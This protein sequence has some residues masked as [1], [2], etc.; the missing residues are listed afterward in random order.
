MNTFTNL[1]DESPSG[2]LLLVP[3]STTRI[4]TSI[5]ASIVAS[6]STIS[7][8]TELFLCQLSILT[9]IQ[10]ICIAC[11]AAVMKRGRT[12]QSGSGEEGRGSDGGE[13]SHGGQSESVK[14][15]LEVPSFVPHQIHHGKMT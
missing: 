11:T 10:G 12:R 15:V 9:T 14:M 7:S 5:V 4:V 6:V 3:I 13:D 2:P 8:V 1:I